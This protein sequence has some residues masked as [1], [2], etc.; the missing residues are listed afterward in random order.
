MF[1]LSSNHRFCLYSQP[2]DMRKSFNGL[3]GIIINEL[4]ENPGS[5]DVF[6]FINKPR[7]KIK[8][9]HWQDMGFTLYYRRLEEGTFEPLEYDPEVGSIR[10][11]YTQ[12]VMLVDGLTIKNI[13]KRKRFSLAEKPVVST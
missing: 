13:H 8:L 5:G 12:M 9:L 10:L 1:T 7:N 3:S 6:I 11:S 4:G 2:T